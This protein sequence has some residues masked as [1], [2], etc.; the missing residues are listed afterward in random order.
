MS[1]KFS[2][3]FYTCILILLFWKFILVFYK[4]LHLRQMVNFKRLNISPSLR[5]WGWCILNILIF[6][7]LKYSNSTR[8]SEYESAGWFY[9]VLLSL[10]LSGPAHFCHKGITCSWPFNWGRVP[11]FV[12]NVKPVGCVG[13]H[14]WFSVNLKQV[15]CTWDSGMSYSLMFWSF[16][17]GRH[18]FLYYGAESIG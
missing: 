5:Y 13:R 9:S 7:H 15:L 1:V 11:L 6:I 14:M 12:F 8:N 2:L 18:I 4:V 17:H 3:L 10:L 16:P